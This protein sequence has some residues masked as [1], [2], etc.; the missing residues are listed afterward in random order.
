MEAT[1][2]R[3]KSKKRNYTIREQKD[4]F[5]WSGKRL[6]HGRLS[7][8]KVGFKLPENINAIELAKRGFSHQCIADT[9]GLT[10]SQVSYRLFKIGISVMEYR[11]GNSDEAQVVLKR[12]KVTYHE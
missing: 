4:R 7:N 12:F 5:Y 2:T 11:R 6:F 9:L 8:G 1:L 10:K 3:T